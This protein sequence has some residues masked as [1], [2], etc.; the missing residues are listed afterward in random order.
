M[1]IIETLVLIIYTY[2]SYYIAEGLHLSG[3]IAIF[4]C[5]ITMGHYSFQNLSS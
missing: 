1:P 2:F 3:I 4:I 5:G